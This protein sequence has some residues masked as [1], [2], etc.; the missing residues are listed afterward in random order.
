MKKVYR[1]IPLTLFL[2]MTS[3]KKIMFLFF[4]KVSVVR[5]NHM[6]NN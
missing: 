4:A 2:T 5:C 6:K 3:S 1:G